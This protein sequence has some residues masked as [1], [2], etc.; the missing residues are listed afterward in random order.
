MSKK[1]EEKVAVI[2]GGNSGIGMAV[3]KLFKAEGARLGLFGRNEET[4]RNVIQELGG[5]DVGFAGDVTS[6]K[7]LDAFFGEV[8]SK[9]GKIDI[10]YVNAGISKVGPI[11]EMTP[12]LYN[13]MFDINVKGAFNSVQRAL[14]MMRNGSTITFT[15][16]NAVHIGHPN[17]SVYSATKAALGSFTKSFAAELLSLGIRVNSVSP[18]PIDTT[19][20]TK[21]MDAKARAAFVQETAK[22]IPMKRMGRADEIAKAVLFL[23][24]DDS[25]FMTG[26]EIIVDGG[27]VILRA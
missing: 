2:T 10:L 12:S 11:A 14:P 8:K 6:A 26:E 13:E 17:L 4:M 1:L 9:Y 3:A 19:L 24:S 20:V 23:A 25:S 15:T 5:H 21:G 18:G 16:S 27:G 22:S 7:D